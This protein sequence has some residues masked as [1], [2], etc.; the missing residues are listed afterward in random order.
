[1]QQVHIALFKHTLE[2]TK[3]FA[4]VYSKLRIKKKMIGSVGK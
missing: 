4:T 1:M 2:V 3:F